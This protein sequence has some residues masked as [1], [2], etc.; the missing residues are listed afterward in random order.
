MTRA[1]EVGYKSVLSAACTILVVLSFFTLE[2]CSQPFAGTS[3]IQRPPE[4]PEVDTVALAN[5]PNSSELRLAHA[6]DR[7]G[8][9]V[10]KFSEKFGMDWALVMAVIHQESKF[11][12]EAVSPNGAYGLMQIMPVTQAELIDKL[13]VDETVTPRNN[14]KAGI[15]HLRKLYG[16]FHGSSKEDRLRL[17]LAAYNA[18]IGRIQDAQRIAAYL[19]N[20]PKRWESVRQALALL[21]RNS[22]TLHARIWPEGKP[23]SGY[24]RNA[25]ETIEYVDAVTDYYQDYAVA[26]K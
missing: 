13:G 9:L 14:I 26:L 24:F 7:Y 15:Y 22:Y 12:H 8:P 25:K 5:V 16:Q 3:F 18:G 19:G 20:D 17:T 11:D 21:S 10:R 2:G 23:S 6:V 1:G 4:S